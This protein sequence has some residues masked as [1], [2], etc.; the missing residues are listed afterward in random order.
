[1]LQLGG[2]VILAS[3]V[4]VPEGWNVDEQLPVRCPSF[5]TDSLHSVRSDV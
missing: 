4:F 3:V 1:M 5:L 2:P